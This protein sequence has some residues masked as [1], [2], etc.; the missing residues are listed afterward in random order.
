VRG[1]GGELELAA[2]RLLHRGLRAQ[3]DQ[4][5]AEEHGQQHDRPGDELGV[6]QQAPRV[7]VAGQALARDQPAATVPGLLQ[8]ERRRRP[9]GRPPSVPGDLPGGVG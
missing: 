2:A 8:P 7:R 5:R 3:A 9:R 6:Q 4:Q 1:V